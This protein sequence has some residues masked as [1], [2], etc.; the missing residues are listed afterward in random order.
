MKATR[1]LLTKILL[2]KAKGYRYSERTDEY[3]VEGGEKVLVRSRT[4]TKS[5]P[6]DVSA[7]KVLIAL[8]EGVPDI[9]QMTDEQLAEEKVRLIK[10]LEGV[11]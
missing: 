10:L 6:P 5:M 2:K 7:I 9:E 1:D 11:D 4:V 8:S 3:A